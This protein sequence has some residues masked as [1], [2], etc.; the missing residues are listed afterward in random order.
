MHT[1]GTP[2]TR[3]DAYRA[4]RDTRTVL[5][6]MG[7]LA[8]HSYRRDERSTPDGIAFARAALRTWPKGS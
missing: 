3:H 5:H 6:R 8:E 7:V 1:D 2:L 4:A